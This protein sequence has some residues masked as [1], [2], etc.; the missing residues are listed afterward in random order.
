MKDLYKLRLLAA[1]ALTVVLG[2]VLLLSPDTASAL[3][4]KILGWCAV[5]GAVAFGAGAFTGAA[6]GRNN[7][8]IWAVVCL[9]GGMW[10][11][12]NPLS[13][14]KFLGRFLGIVLMIRGGQSAAD[15]IRYQGKKLVKSRGLILGLVTAAVGAVLVLLPLATS[16]LFFKI[17]G[18]GLIGFG[19]AQGAD[20]LREKKRLE[21]P[22]DPNIIDVEKL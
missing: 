10:L 11:L 5:I 3:V 16:R 15:N 21:E 17:V 1:P 9:A 14:A 18:I 2:L 22:G 12:R 8:I 20:R 4:G 7:R 19:I 6:D 13:V